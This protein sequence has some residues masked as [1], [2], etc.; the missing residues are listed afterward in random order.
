MWR[1]IALRIV[2]VVPTLLMVL[3]LVFVAMRILPG[4]P[5]LA[6]LGE[7]ATAQQLDDF[8]HKIGLDQPLWWQYASFLVRS[9][10]FS[11]GNSFATTFSVAQL[12]WLNLPY[13][14]ELTVWATLIGTVLAVPMGVVAAVN[15]GKAIDSG[16]RIFS[17]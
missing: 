12:V 3:T 8:R 15:R 7:H 6:V 10:I 14:V 5:A 9:V 11:F 4:D 16:T 17:L 2:D 1:V 13:T